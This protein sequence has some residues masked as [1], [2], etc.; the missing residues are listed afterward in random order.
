[1]LQ[2][3]DYLEIPELLKRNL[4]IL[5]YQ[6]SL[7]LLEIPELLKQNPGIPEH[8]VYL[9]ALAVLAGLLGLPPLKW[10][11]RLLHGQQLMIC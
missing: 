10:P 9:E 6:I 3:L 5:V 4:G 8:P 2:F 1:L 7:A 11:T